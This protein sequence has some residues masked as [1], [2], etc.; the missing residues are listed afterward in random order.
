MILG[1]GG[2]ILSQTHLLIINYSMDEKSQIF[3]HQVDLVNQL[4]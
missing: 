4:A 3:S 2:L 1:H